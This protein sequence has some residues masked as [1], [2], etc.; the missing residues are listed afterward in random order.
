MPDVV[1]LGDINIDIS[2][3][4]PAYPAR[5]GEGVTTSVEYN[6]G[7]SVVTTSLALANMGADVGVLGRIGTDA[8]ATQA[9]ADLEAIGVDRSQIQIDQ[10]VSTGLIYIVVNPD[11][12]RTMF[13]SRGANVF[14]TPKSTW[15]AYFSNTRWYHFSGYALMSQPQQDAA[16]Y[17][18]ELARQNHCRVSLD[19][20]PE[21]AMRYSNRVLELLS[22]IDIFMPN[23]M[24]LM[25]ISGETNLDD[26]IRR[27]LNMGVKAVVVKRGKRG[28][29][30]AHN[31][32]TVQLPPFEVNVKDSTGAGDSFDAG[33]LFGRMVGLSWE[34]SGVLGNALGA[35]ATSS[36]GTG[37]V[38][39]NPDS[40]IEM[41]EANMFKPEWQEWHWAIEQILA[42]LMAV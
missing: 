31:K 10:V 25:V 2:A 22:K 7:G 11:G 15:D 40:V 37:G 42:Y 19:P 6:T 16:I 35:I 20:N 32:K 34:A 41:L 9:L 5:G 18:L 30:I 21:P 8:L 3:S 38:A 14:T 33:V 4:M 13:S 1:L 24:E 27:T 29:V 17:A 12:E 36:H 26:A 39:I 28:C 23:E